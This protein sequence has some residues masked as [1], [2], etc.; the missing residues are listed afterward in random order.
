VIS[1][2]VWTTF[3]AGGVYPVVWIPAAIGIAALAVRLRP[4]I[5]GEARLLDVS[6]ICVV[7]AILAQLIPLP[8][9]VLLRIDSTARLL[10]GLLSLPIAP[11]L[12]ISIVPGDTLAAAGITCAAV[13]TFWVARQLCESGRAGRLIR[14]IAVIGLIGS[15][16]AIVQSSASK[17]LL[18]GMWRPFDAGARPYGPFVNRNHFAAWVMMACPLTFGYLLA[19]APEPREERTLSQ[20]IVDAVMQL[21]SFRLWLATAICIMTVAVV[22][23]GSRSGV[24]GLICGFVVNSWLSRGRS[25]NARGWTIFQSLLVVVALLTLASFDVLAGRLDETLSQTE[26]L[27]GR[28]AIWHDAE[29]I[30]ADFRW[31]GTGAGTFGTAVLPYQTSAPGY[32]VGQ[33]HNHY[34]QLAA[35]GGLLLVLP[36]TAAIVAFLQIF[37]RRLKVDV[38]GPDFLI[39][40]GAGAGMAAVMVQSIWET[41]LRM[42][43]N[44]MLFGLL[45]AIACHSTSE[46]HRTR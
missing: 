46:W 14:A 1:L 13:L 15:V 45:A 35:E 44:A 31:T 2:L 38:D 43:A 32:A 36:A 20:R 12:P 25:Q 18:Y 42:P 19:R 9:A 10:R 22:I 30:A 4:G 16:A 24:I 5:A 26:T 17:E 41:G 40:A 28:R 8:H 27:H 6:L 7:L 21:E 39:R 11:T 3:L 29:T 23:S 33:A 34:L 37:R